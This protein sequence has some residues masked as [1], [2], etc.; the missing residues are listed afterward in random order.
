MRSFGMNCGAVFA[1]AL[2]SFVALQTVAQ[3]NIVVPTT[4]PGELLRECQLSGYGCK[5][6]DC[7]THA[8]DCNSPSDCNCKPS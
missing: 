3:A 4:N 5:K 6:G 1:C 8:E 2:L 7:P